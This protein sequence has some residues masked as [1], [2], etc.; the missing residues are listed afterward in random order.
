MKYT[1]VCTYRVGPFETKA[2]RCEL[3]SFK[4]K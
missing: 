1:I 2:T 4:S 3:R